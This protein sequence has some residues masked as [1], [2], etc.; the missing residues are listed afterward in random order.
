MKVVDLFAGC[1]GL[2]K[3]FI[4]A[5]IN[6]VAA[7]DNWEPAIQCY[8]EN[9]NHPI[10][11][12][13]L[14]N[15]E[16]ACNFIR[17]F[18][19]DMIIGGPPCQEFSHAGPRQ[20]GERADLTKHFAKTV[21][22]IHPK[23]FLMENV[24]RIK[25]SRAFA[26]ARQIFKASGYGL[27]EK[28]ITA[29][30]CG[31]PQN[32]KR[33]FCIG[34]LGANDG[35]LEEEINKNLSNKRTTV[36]DYLR[37][38]LDIEYYYRHPRNYSRR[39]IFSID[40]PAPTIRGV[41]RPVPKGYPGHRSDPAPVGPALRSL[42]TLERARLQTFPRDYRWVGSKTDLEQMIGN[43]VPVLLARFVASI[44]LSKERRLSDAG[45]CPVQGV[46]EA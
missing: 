15:V 23:W 41:N 31:V 35:F 22:S 7:F 24:D 17:G 10:F 2:S 25:N 46:V 14:N 26:E 36:R 13:D 38:E 11:K 16:E 1:G 27:T 32:R 44:I 34:L 3:G 4:D 43:S 20:E 45:P 42:T 33:F 8:T 5:G 12:V 39:G 30:F 18:N 9:F 6:I 19:P 28:I 29:S 21:V 40:E 37:D